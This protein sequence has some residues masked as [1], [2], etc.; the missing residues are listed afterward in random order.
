[1]F[2]LESR[3]AGPIV[4]EGCGRTRL[5]S[6][7]PAT[8]NTDGFVQCDSFD[9]RVRS[10]QPHR[11]NV[12]LQL[13]TA[14]AIAFGAPWQ[15]PNRTQSRASERFVGEWSV[16]SRLWRAQAAELDLCKSISKQAHKQSPLGF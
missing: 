9:S 6:E 7:D 2:V 15:L 13:T 12:D 14:F 10:S 5:S 11:I 16:R 8:A 1:M 4:V 3:L